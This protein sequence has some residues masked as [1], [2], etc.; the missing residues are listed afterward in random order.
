MKIKDMLLWLIHPLEG[1]ATVLFY[2]R[3]SPVLAVLWFHGWLTYERQ[4]YR[5][6]KDT[7]YQDI[8]DFLIGYFVATLI[9][10][11]AK[12]KGNKHGQM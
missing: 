7:C 12:K 2:H 1:A 4:E 8:R 10:S 6:D 11:L 5:Q 3:A 9:V